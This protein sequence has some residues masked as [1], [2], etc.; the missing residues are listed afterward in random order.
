[1]Y[2]INSL[3]ELEKYFKENNINNS[4]DLAN[5]GAQYWNKTIKPLIH[6]KL[7]RKPK[8]EKHLQKLINNNYP[9]LLI[10]TNYIK[11]FNSLFKNDINNNNNLKTKKYWINPL[12]YLGF[13]NTSNVKDMSFCFHRQTFFNQRLYWDTKNVKDTSYMFSYCEKYNQP[14]ELDL[15]SCENIK[16]M[17]K[18][19]YELNQEIDLGNLNKV[20]DASYMF[21]Y[22]EKLNRPIKL[23]LPN[24]ENI[25]NIFE[26][27]E[28]LNG[29]IKLEN[30]DNIKNSF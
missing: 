5:L 8:N 18:S 20:K 30:L 24:C 4:D 12:N 6:F 19:C 2:Q 23:S 22:C 16:G 27:S 3:K 9:L 10:N 21:S 15:S 13:W 17:F 28:C 14:T 29:I 26:Y 1:M 7:F 11:D 25:E